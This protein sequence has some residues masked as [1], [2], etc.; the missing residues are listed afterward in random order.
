MTARYDT[1]IEA[2]KYGDHDRVDSL[3]RAGANVDRGIQRVYN[4]M[5]LWNASRNGHIKCVELLLEAGIGVNATDARGMT[6]L[7]LAAQYGYNDCVQLLLEKGADVNVSEFISG[8]SALYYAAEGCFDECVNLLIKAGADVNKKVRGIDTLL[9]LACVNWAGMERYTNIFIEAGADVNSRDTNGSTPLI[10]ASLHGEARFVALLI[11]AGADVNVVSKAGNS[12]LMMAAKSSSSI[13]RVCLLLQAGAFVN[14]PSGRR[15][16]RIQLSFNKKLPMLLFAAGETLDAKIG[17]QCGIPGYVKDSE[18]EL[19]LRDICRK[20]IR[21]H[22]IKMSPA[23]NLFI[24]MPRLGL[25]KSVTS[26]LLFDI[27][28]HENDGTI[29]SEKLL[30]D[31]TAQI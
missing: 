30:H 25:P 9:G 13:G 10:K 19:D 15:G 16:L 23:M 17:M 7:M 18:F 5:A 20:A 11:R 31:K 28:L 3:L 24:Q 21:G 6:F 4:Y 14:H 2:A 22:L 27:S 1:I 12:P 8:I 26:Y 29:I